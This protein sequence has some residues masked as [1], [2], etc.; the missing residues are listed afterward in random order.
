MFINYKCATLISN[1][2]TV[3]ELFEE[4][5]D[6]FVYSISLKAALYTQSCH[7]LN[8]EHQT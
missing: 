2:F 7:F 1:C 5:P 6:E 8:P 3:L 4:K